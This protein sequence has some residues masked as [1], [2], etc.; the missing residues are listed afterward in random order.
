MALLEVKNITAKYGDE[1][2]IKDISFSLE[3]GDYLIVVGENGT[4]KSTLLKVLTGLWKQSG[5]EVNFNCINRHDIGYLPQQNILQK[6]FPAK[7]FEIVC[8]GFSGYLGSVFLSKHNK[9]HAKHLIEHIGLKDISDKSF[10]N[11]SG[12]QQQ[13]VLLARA[14]VAGEGM[15]LLDEPVASLDPAARDEI[16]ATIEHYNKIH[17]TTVIMVTHDIE[18]AIKYANKVLIIGENNIFCTAEEY[19]NMKGGAKFD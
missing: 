11:L 9:S 18:G 4:G 10:A 1:E 15:L 17:G 13:K 7:V 2:V 3:R 16:Y 19:L 12:G 5:G 8:S 14:L 6:N